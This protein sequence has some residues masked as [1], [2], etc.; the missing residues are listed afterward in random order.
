MFK[1]IINIIFKKPLE[2]LI[3]DLKELYL[4]KLEYVFVKMDFLKILNNNKNFNLER[5]INY[6]VFTNNN[7][8]HFTTGFKPIKY[9]IVVLMNYSKKFM[10]ILYYLLVI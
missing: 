9:S 5:D 3:K 10:K 7:T 2:G 6:I 1:K 8:L 4:I